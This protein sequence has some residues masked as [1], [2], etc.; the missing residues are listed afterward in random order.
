M[1]AE[2]AWAKRFETDPGKACRSGFWDSLEQCQPV[3]PFVLTGKTGAP[4]T[5]SHPHIREN[6]RHTRG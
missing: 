3:M 5:V 6:S 1:R 4:P 2:H